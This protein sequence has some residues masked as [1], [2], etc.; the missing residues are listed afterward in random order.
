M[1]I[2]IMSNLN[3]LLLKKQKNKMIKNSYKIPSFNGK[4][5]GNLE[6]NEYL[7]EK[8][9]SQDLSFL[10]NYY[11]TDKGNKYGNAHNYVLY[12]QKHFDRIK[13]KNLNILEIGIAAGSSLK[14]WSSYFTNSNIYGIDINPECLDIESLKTEDF[15]NIKLILGDA[16]KHDFKDIKFDIIIDDGSHLPIDIYFTY[17]NLSKK[18]NEKGIYVIED[19]K[20]CESK[21]YVLALKKCKQ[22]FRDMTNQKY[23][24]LN[25][26]QA[27]NS[28]LNDIQNKTVSIYKNKKSEIAFIY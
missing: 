4:L 22:E 15:K 5:V 23:I 27:L 3:K 12:Y 14:M 21:G 26:K 1:I 18:L 2:N 8:V 24:S 6:I 28:F 9:N 13:D 20:T 19:L 25:S 17:K 7:K 10:A 11:I 16:S